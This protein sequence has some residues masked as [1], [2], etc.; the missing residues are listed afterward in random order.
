MVQQPVSGGKRG[1]Y[2]FNKDFACFKGIPR[3]RVITPSGKNQVK[4][5]VS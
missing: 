2:I 3:M 5:I 4:Q 1:E